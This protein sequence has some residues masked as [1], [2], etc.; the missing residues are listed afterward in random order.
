M[1]RYIYLFFLLFCTSAFLHDIHISKGLVEYNE[2]ENAL[3]ITLHIFVDDLEDAIRLKHGHENLQIGTEKEHPEAEI[4]IEEYLR[5]TFS[6]TVDGE[7]RSF[8]LLG[9]E[10]SDDYMAVW[11]YLEISEVPPF[12]KLTLHNSI[13]M[14]LFDDQSNIVTVK[15]P[16]GKRSGSLFQQTERTRDFTFL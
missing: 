14:D 16:D 10:L 8:T 7:K 2:A 4:Y 13:L 6:L 12:K 11:C 15:G 1:S 3:Q 5:E 9:K